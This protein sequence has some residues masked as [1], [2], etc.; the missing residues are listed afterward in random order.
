MISG[1]ISQEAKRQQETINLIA[2]ENYVSA[3]V[4][5]ALASDL[6]NKYAE[7]QPGWRYYGGIEF[8]DKIENEVKQ[9][10]QRVFQTDYALNVQAY[11]GSIANLAIYWALLEPGEGIMG[12]QLSHGGHLTHGHPVTISGKLYQRTAYHIDPKTF[13]LDYEEI[14]RL[15]K[16]HKPKLIISGASAYS[17]QI[18]FQRLSDIAHSVGA[19]HLAD[20]S[21]ISGLIAAGLHPSPFGNAD[22]VM[23][24]THKILRGPRGALIFSKPELAEKI[25][26][27]IFPG[28]QGGPHMNTIAA[29]GVCLE[30]ATTDQYRGY[31]VRV[32]ENA[33]I[34]ADEL[35]KLG[36]EIITGGTD[37]HLFLVDL[38]PLKL[39][40]QEA[41]D[42]L[43][44]VGITVNKNAIPYDEASP[45]NPSGIRLGTPAITTHGITKPELTAL[46][47][48]IAKTLQI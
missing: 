18:D 4:K 7:G 26:K 17:R 11:S 25:D 27:A 32:Q 33:R 36:L 31:V 29:I 39:T 34:L 42:R 5:E 44:K 1:L 15:A 47:Q 24:T 9:L 40:G 13:L 8:V 45:M 37:N 48:K 35:K 19:C 22:V 30:E 16:E 3:A 12:L 23:T 20:I 38:R 14:E 43:E 10:G 28:I 2:S 46:A 21:H 6:T 41:Q